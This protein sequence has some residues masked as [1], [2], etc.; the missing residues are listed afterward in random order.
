MTIHSF[1]PNQESWLHYWP[2]RIV[3]LIAIAQLLFSFAIVIL[4]SAI[5]A[6]GISS[7]CIG[8]TPWFIMGFVCW[9]IFLA[10]WISVFCV[11]KYVLFHVFVHSTELNEQ[12]VP[13]E[14]FS[15]L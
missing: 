12:I 14:Y 8:A 7:F 2:A 5:V 6:I 10:C 15:L 11:S 1:W 3:S 13:V 9:A 4:H